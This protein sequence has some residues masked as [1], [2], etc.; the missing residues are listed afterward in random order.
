MKKQCLSGA[1]LPIWGPNRS[2]YAS[3]D[4]FPPGQE[5]SVLLHASAAG[6]RAANVVTQQISSVMVDAWW[7]SLRCAACRRRLPP[8]SCPAQVSHGEGAAGWNIQRAANLNSLVLL[9]QKKKKICEKGQNEGSLM[10][11]LISLHF[12]TNFSSRS[13]VQSRYLIKACRNFGKFEFEK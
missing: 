7:S 11:Y 10:G 6:S 9:R 5:M 3:R 13:E 12:H 4:S 1:P 8:S 2:N